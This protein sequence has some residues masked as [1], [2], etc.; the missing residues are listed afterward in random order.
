M[1]VPS[2]FDPGQAQ[3]GFITDSFNGTLI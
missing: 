3:H 1:G 2:H